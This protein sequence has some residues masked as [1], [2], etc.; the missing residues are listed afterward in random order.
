MPHW[1]P[2]HLDSHWVPELELADYPGRKQG[3]AEGAQ[4]TVATEG[5]PVAGGARVPVLPKSS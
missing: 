2:L 3:W 5:Q 1:L 4:P